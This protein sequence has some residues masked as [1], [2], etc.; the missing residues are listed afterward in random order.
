MKHLFS[1]IITF[2]FSELLVVF[3]VQLE[4]PMHRRS[5]DGA[6]YGALEPVPMG[7]LGM[8]IQ[9]LRQM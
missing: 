8:E 9:N 2:I 3:G 1:Q 6:P 5:N 4:L 7:T